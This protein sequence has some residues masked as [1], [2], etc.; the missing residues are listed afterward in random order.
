MLVLGRVCVLFRW[1]DTLIIIWEYDD[2]FLGYHF[3]TPP[4]KDPSEPRSKKP[5]PTFYWKPGW[6][7]TGSLCHGLWNNAL[8]NWVVF[9]PLY[10]PTN[11]GCFHCSR[12]EKH[13]RKLQHTRYRTPVRQSPGNANYERNPLNK[14]VVKGCSGCV[15]KVCRNNL[16]KQRL[17]VEKKSG[18]L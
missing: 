7:M 4:K 8:Y 17:T 18:G 12:E 15:P 9:D 10:N 5:G 14:P 11:Q 3:P 2:W 6:L 13:P 1:L 16:R